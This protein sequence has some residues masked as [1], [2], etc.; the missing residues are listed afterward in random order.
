[1]NRNHG[2]IEGK[3]TRLGIP[4]GALTAPAEIAYATNWNIAKMAGEA[5]GRAHVGY[6]Q[7]A[8]LDWLVSQN[9]L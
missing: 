2:H 5:I 7:A 8:A 6:D 9:F 3:L 1:M 4:P